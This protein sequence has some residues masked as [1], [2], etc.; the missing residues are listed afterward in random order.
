[1][2][3]RVEGTGQY[4]KEPG[5]TA[6]EAPTGRQSYFLD[7]AGAANARDLSVVSFEAVERMGEPYRI[8]IELTHP[9]ELSRS[10]Y[11]G[12]DASFRIGAAD[13]T[14]R[15][16]FSGCITRFSKTRT[17]KDFGRYRFVVE[18][19]I[20][21]LSLVRTSR[22]YQHQ[23]VPQIIESIL[24]RHG[25]RGHQLTFSLRRAY[26]QHRFRFQH[27]I[28]DWPYIHMLMQQ[29]G[30][31]SYIVQGQHGDVVVFA[32]D[33]DHYVYQPELKV[34][35]REMAGLEAGTEC[36]SALRTHVR[37]VPESFA[38]ADYNPDQAWERFRGEANVARKD[39]TTYGQPY[40][41]GTHHLDQHGAQWEA[42]LRHEAAIA[43]QIVY[44]GES[45]VPE[46]RPGRIL[47]MDEDL[48]DAPHGQLVIEATHTG[49][50][51]A[52]YCNTYKAIPADRR[53]R[54]K[55]EE[56]KWPKINGT[57]SAR[58]T[59]PGRYK[60]AY[61]TQHGHYTVR[62][63]CDFDVW[64]PGGESVPLRLAK[65]FAGALQTGFHFPAL[66]G[67]EAVIGFRDG[68]PNKPYISQFHHHS[69]ATDLITNQ[70]RWMS[71]GVI[72]TQSN[73]QLEFEDWAGE[74]HVKLSSEHSGK[75]QLTLGHIVDGKRQKRGEG[76]ELRTS[77]HGAIRGGKGLFFS[78]DDQPDAGGRQLDMEAAKRR[79]QQ[80][81]QQTEALAAAAEAAQAVAA[82]YDR[83]KA[84]LNDTLLELKKAGMLASAP[85]GIALVS[86][87]DLQVSAADNLIATAGGHADFSV[88]KRLTV[89]AGERISVFAQKL[90][91]Q[92]FAAQGKVE[93]QAQ[94]DEMRLLADKDMRVT[95]AN[96]RVVIEAKEELLL[97]C[98][99][100]YLRMTSTGIEDGTRGD[101][102]CRAASFGRQGPASVT[103]SP[104]NFSHPEVA[105]LPAKSLTLR[106]VA[107]PAARLALP[108]GMPYRLLADGVLMK[109]GVLDAT[110]DIPVEHRSTA[111]RYTVELASGAAYELPVAEAYRGD[112]PNGELAN[113]GVHFHEG[114]AHAGTAT[115]DRAAH[116]QRYRTLLNPETDS[117]R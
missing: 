102:T 19:H 107:S 50:R 23:S 1:M 68:D 113:V 29:E 21:R 40:I 71:R 92:L 5:T 27:Q 97:K 74:E 8:T 51:D 89:A 9:D 95:S 36:V 37:T 2:V 64:N 96:G 104:L 22:I 60:Y 103:H 16:R 41:Y 82:D 87:S 63:D 78:A 25:F 35:Y 14:A 42:Q 58:V 26:A 98:G 54:L 48:P 45:N 81:L 32:D 20:A 46:L 49:A 72:R 15:R 76:F 85:A 43:W 62:F 69:Q 75:S 59:S 110:G 66:D 79:L 100:S 55:L 33:I 115:A 44:D 65:P 83:Q 114:T 18:A 53:F 38:V 101:R 17:T 57:L 112:V 3:H 24:R 91:I 106:A 11:L 80:A 105:A 31:Y 86:G 7:V 77:G 99:G 10:D 52:A 56:E 70:D 67:T 30:I 28:A 84:L 94:S 88:L 6:R 111:S 4:A 93:I 117:P 34:P 13:G 116:R 12:R 47:Q 61:L 90:G 109:Q 108:K 73:N 39:T